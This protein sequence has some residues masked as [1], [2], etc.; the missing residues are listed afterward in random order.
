MRELIIKL[1]QG[2]LGKLGGGRKYQ[3]DCVAY[4]WPYEFDESGEPIYNPI[5]KDGLREKVIKEA[6]EKVGRNNYTLVPVLDRGVTYIFA[7]SG[8]LKVLKLNT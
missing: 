3:A 2:L 1:L 5:T 8:T 7:V 4:T 6:D